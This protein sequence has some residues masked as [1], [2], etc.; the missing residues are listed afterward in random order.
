MLLDQLNPPIRRGVAIERFVV[1]LS[2]VVPS[3]SILPSGRTAKTLV[4]G[5]KLSDRFRLYES[6]GDQ[7]TWVPMSIGFGV[8]AR[9]G[10]FS[11]TDPS[12]RLCWRLPPR[13][14]CPQ[15]KRLV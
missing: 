14:S 15:G 7:V 10:R 12:V 3:V 1:R 2:T 8:K 9:F 13:L 5:G 4:A 11:V 6:D